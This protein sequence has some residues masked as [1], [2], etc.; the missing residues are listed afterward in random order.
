MRCFIGVSCSFLLVGCS[1]ANLD[2]LDTTLAEIRR[3][4]VGQAPVAVQ[5]LPSSR[6]LNYEYGEA[7]SP[8]LAPDSFSNS[9]LA[10]PLEISEFSPDQQRATEP[11]ERFQLASLRLVGTLRMDDRRIAL[12]VSPDGSMTSVREGNYLGSNHGRITHV[13]A[14]E[15]TLQERIYS[16][17]QGWQERLV[18]LSLD[19]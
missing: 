16:Q 10:V 14:K 11:M 6:T 13:G 19:E 5:T 1:D 4:H 2:Q 17:S 3:A 8:F 12:I 7:R 9:E 18:T 15:V